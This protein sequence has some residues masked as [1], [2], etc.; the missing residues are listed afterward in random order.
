MKL[1]SLVEAVETRYW[2]PKDNYLQIIV[3]SL[4]GRIID[5]DIVAVSEKALSTAK[6]RIID[7]GQVVPG[8]LAKFLARF[9]M[10]IIWG[11]F[12][13]RICHLKAENIHR[14]R[15]YPLKEGS[16][17]KQVV[18][19]H[20]SFLQA[21]CWGSEGGIDASNLPRSYVSLPL[22]GPQETAEEIRL[23]LRNRLGKNITVLLVDT[24]KTYSF[25]GFHFTHRPKPLIPIRSF[26][27]VVA[28]VAGRSLR[29]KR[30]STPLAVAGS[31]IDASSALDLAE[32][33]NKCRG[34]GTG[35]TVWDMAE[36]FGVSITSVTWSMIESFK[37]KP[38][39]ILKCGKR[40]GRY[41]KT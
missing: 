8:V 26:F 30:R 5:G 24:D 17:H 21:L 33:A 35:P 27:G 9:W 6:G 38:L 39:V 28:Y 34:S 32:A 31:R 25:R 10:R 40:L 11:Y 36:K 7:E 18:L 4:K 19:W 13:G 1:K 3:E 41:L 2:M 14:L 16:A 12:L 20:A 29:L 15:N 37:H 22:Y 23:F